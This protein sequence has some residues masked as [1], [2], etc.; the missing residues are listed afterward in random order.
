MSRQTKAVNTSLSE[1]LPV[2][3]RQLEKVA[4]I[5]PEKIK[6]LF[7]VFPKQF[8]ELW[9]TVVIGAYLNDDINLSKAAELLG[10]H[11]IE[12]RNDFIKQ[13]IPIKI[14]TQSLEEA[15][16]EINTLKIL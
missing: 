14:G 6:R 11:P 12:L 8:P 13:G 10:K 7:D 3:L 4:Q 15:K 1:T 5:E 16:A 9:R 2:L